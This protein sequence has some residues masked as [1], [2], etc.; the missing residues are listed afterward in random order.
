MISHPPVFAA[1]ASAYPRSSAVT[2]LARRLWDADNP[3]VRPM[4]LD[5][6]IQRL[7]DYQS[8]PR[9]IYYPKGMD[10]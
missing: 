1:A 9:N 3:G 6:A 5:A 7:W 2:E 10:E 4:R 8:H